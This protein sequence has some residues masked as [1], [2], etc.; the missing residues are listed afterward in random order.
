MGPRSVRNAFEC[1]T[2]REV[3]ET[4]GVL[5][6]PFFDQFEDLGDIVKA[7][8]E[9]RR[10]ASSDETALY[11][12]AMAFLVQGKKDLAFESIDGE[13]GPL[14]EAM[15]DQGRSSDGARLERLKAFRDFIQLLADSGGC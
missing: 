2:R 4:I 11:N 5:A 1:P 13:V 9:G 10:Y 12:L 15:S 6:I 8:Q 14:S 7:I 3:V